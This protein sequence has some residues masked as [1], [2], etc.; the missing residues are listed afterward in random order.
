MA[1]CE[2]NL[3]GS[4]MTKKAKLDA[5]YQTTAFEAGYVQYVQRMYLG[6]SV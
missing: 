1:T 3:A 2:A 5:E 4:D 6:C